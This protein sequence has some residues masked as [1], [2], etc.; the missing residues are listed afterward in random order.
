[1]AARM[2]GAAAGLIELGTP[3]REQEGCECNS[4][5]PYGHQRQD[6]DFEGT[7]GRPPVMPRLQFAGIGRIAKRKLLCSATDAR[8][9]REVN[10]LR[11]G[12]S[13]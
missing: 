13:D 9:L 10:P 12:E 2:G 1:M 5:R 6:H 7:H 8:R 3:G 11:L 4:R